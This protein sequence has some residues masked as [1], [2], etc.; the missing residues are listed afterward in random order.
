MFAFLMVERH[1]MCFAQ[2]LQM[3]GDGGLGDVELV[4][5]DIDVLIFDELFE[6]H[7]LFQ[8]HIYPPL[9]NRENLY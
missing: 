1:V 6:D 7:Q 3:E 9:K 8:V 2:V 4:G 5:D